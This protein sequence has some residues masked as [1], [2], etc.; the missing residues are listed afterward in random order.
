MII[1]HHYL[2]SFLGSHLNIVLFLNCFLSL[3]ALHNFAPRHIRDLLHNYAPNRRLRSPTLIYKL[4]HRTFKQCHINE[5]FII[6]IIIIIIIIV[7]TIILKLTIPFSFEQMLK[8]T[9]GSRPKEN[10][11]VQ[12]KKVLEVL[13]EESKTLPTDREETRWSISPLTKNLPN[14]TQSLIHFSPTQQCHP[15][16]LLLENIDLLL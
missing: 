3:K 7:I 8:L 11:W 14:S 6:I 5:Y 4:I 2:K 15:L 13:G 9:R 1:L 10:Y 16:F 12:W